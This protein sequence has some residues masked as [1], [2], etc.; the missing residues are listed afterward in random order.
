MKLFVIRL[1]D[2]NYLMNVVIGSHYLRYDRT[3][4][5]GAAHLLNDFDSQLMLKRLRN[6]GEKNAQREDGSEGS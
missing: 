1:E 5:R 2:G 4:D 6:E 3:R